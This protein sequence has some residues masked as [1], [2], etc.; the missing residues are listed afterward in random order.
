[1]VLGTAVVAMTAWAAT[2]EVDKV[3]RGSGRV[4]PMVQNQMVQNLEG[5]IV[6]EI[7]VREGQRVKRGDVL[8]RLSNQ[9]TNAELSNAQTDVVARRIALA[10]MDA[11]SRGASSFTA[12]AELARLAP[13]IAA[14]EEAL[15]SSRRS[16]VNQELA[17]LDDRIRAL[18]SELS[19]LDQRIANLRTEEGLMLKQLSSLER[20]LAAEAVSE[21]D[22]MERRQSLQQLRTRMADASNQIPQTRAELGEAEGRRR[23]AWLRFVSENKER[24][25]EI[26]LQ[27]AK[28]GEALGA[29]QD[30]DRRANLQAPMDGVVNKVFVQTVGGVVQPGQDLVEIVPVDSSVIIEARVDPEDRGKIWPGLPATVK[31]SAYE[32]SVHGGLSGEVVD[33]SADALQ[34]PEGKTYY[35]VRLK[36]D[37]SRFGTDRPVMPGMTA[38]VDIKSGSQT[39]L[40]Y[41]LS[42]VR[43]VSG[44]AFQ[45]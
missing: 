24:G 18:K 30:R 38:E 40:Q 9:F 25:A 13:S 4:L 26:R 22:V 21:S 11:E 7:L 1:M 19:A 35:R 15:F 3:T 27:L 37:T 6:S 17:T 34:D 39:V 43:R 14:S 23:E 41:I 5:G 2:F 33:I 31:V 12:P 10:R 28:A 29:F 42:P 20:A 8:M 44:N 45:E 36:A 16:Q 32:F